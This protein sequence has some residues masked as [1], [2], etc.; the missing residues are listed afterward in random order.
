MN[1]RYGAGTWD[2]ME[3]SAKR[4]AKIGQFE[5]D[6][7]EKYYKQKLKEMEPPTEVLKLS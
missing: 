7:L 2:L 5:I 4:P 3:A 1:K 6:Q